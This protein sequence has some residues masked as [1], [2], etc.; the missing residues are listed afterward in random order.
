MSYISD[1]LEAHITDLAIKNVGINA[2]KDWQLKIIKATLEGRNILIIQPTGSGKSLCFQLL[3]FITGKITI[4]FTPTIS[5]M[6]DQCCALEKKNISA[7]Y[8]GSS[9]TDKGIDTKIIARKFNL[10]YTT[11]EKFFDDTGSPSCPFKDLI[12]TAQVG[13]IAVDEVHLIDSWK[14]FTY[15]LKSVIC[16]YHFV[17]L[18]DQ[19]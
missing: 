8:L 12:M 14:F 2:L 3:P 5:L 15:K 16:M 1:S 7:T 11:P 17:L 10:L 19:Q 18:L 6:K 9:Q 4:V 13:L